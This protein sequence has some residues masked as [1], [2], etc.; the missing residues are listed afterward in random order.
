[1]GD[2]HPVCTDLLPHALNKYFKG[3]GFPLPFHMFPTFFIYWYEKGGITIS[4]Q[5]SLLVRVYTS[6]SYIP[7][8]NVPVTITQTDPDGGQKLIA[9]RYTDSS[10]LTEPI[11]IDTPDM[12]QSLH[13]TNGMQPFALINIQISEPGYQSIR[14]NGIQVFS[15]I[16]TVQNFQ[17]Q[18]LT[19]GES[20]SI[21]RPTPPV[22]NL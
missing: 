14:A 9:I 17:L 1:M 22:Q 18:P 3:S 21:T 15:G 16:E 20:P 6:D 7:L 4:S 11:F 13:P 2:F 5:G 8:R 10:G 12:Q 19:Y